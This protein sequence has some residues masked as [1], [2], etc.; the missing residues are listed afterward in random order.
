[1]KVLGLQTPGFNL[2]AFKPM[3]ILL[4]IGYLISMASFAPKQAIWKIKYESTIIYYTAVTTCLSYLALVCLLCDS[5]VF[6]ILRCRWSLKSCLC[7]CYVFLP[8]PNI[9]FLCIFPLTTCKIASGI[10]T[11]PT[12]Y[13]I[14]IIATWL[15]IISISTVATKIGPVGLPQVSVT[16]Y[17]ADS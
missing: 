7:I 3:V 9:L 16:E 12:V 13:E 14:I 5:S 1:M 17:W 4:Y 11:S 8:K 10:S 15:N 6:F 2:C